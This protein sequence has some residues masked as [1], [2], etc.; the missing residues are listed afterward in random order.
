MENYQKMCARV[1]NII[2]NRGYRLPPEPLE[3]NGTYIFNIY[4]N[5]IPNN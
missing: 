1:E 3:N 2:T 4:H 5:E